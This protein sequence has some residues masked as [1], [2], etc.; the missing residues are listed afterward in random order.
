MMV[1]IYDWLA[2]GHGDYPSNLRHV[3]FGIIRLAEVFGFDPERLL[4]VEFNRSQTIMM[5]EISQRWTSFR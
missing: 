4:P 2:Y 3:T 1:E 5:I